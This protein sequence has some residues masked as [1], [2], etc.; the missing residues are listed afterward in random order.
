M[1]RG[2]GQ[3]W[4]EQ[5]SDANGSP[6]AL[7]KVYH[8]AAGT[9]T[10]AN[11][12]SDE[13][14]TTTVAQPLV[15]DSSGRATAY[16]DNLYKIVVK[17]A[18]DNTLYTWDNYR[19]M[20]EGDTARAENHGT[21][22]PA[23]NANNDFMLFA[24]HDGSNI[25]T[26]L[27]INSNN[28][29]IGIAKPIPSS[30]FY[31]SSYASLAAAI[32]A[33]GST[34]GILEF[35][36]TI[37]GANNDTVPS[38]LELK[39]NKGEGQLTVPASSL[40]Y[41][42][43]PVNAGNYQIYSI[44]GSY[45]STQGIRYF[46]S[47]SSGSS[48]SKI[49]PMHF[50]VL[51]DWNGSNEATTATDNS[52]NLQRAFDAV[53]MSGVIEFP[54]SSDRGIMFKDTNANSFAIGGTSG[55]G[56][57]NSNIGCVMNGNIQNVRGNKVVLKY[58]GTA[59]GMY[60]RGTGSSIADIDLVG[61]S[62]ASGGIYL[63]NNITRIDNVWVHGCGGL[64]W[65]LDGA[66][67][68]G[69]VV[70]SGLD[71]N[72]TVNASNLL[73]A[74]T[75]GG[76]PSSTFQIRIN[77]D[78][79][80]E[81]NIL[82]FL[83]C[84]STFS[85]GVRNSAH[86]ANIGWN[87]RGG[88]KITLKNCLTQEGSDGVFINAQDHIV[89]HNGSGYRCILAHKSASATEPGVGASW[90]TYWTAHT[91]PTA[92]SAPA[93]YTNQWA[94]GNFYTAYAPNKISIDNHWFESGTITNHIY[95]DFNNWSSAYGIGLDYMGAATTQLKNFGSGNT[96]WYNGSTN[97]IDAPRLY[98][99]DSQT[100]SPTVITG[101]DSN[102]YTCIT[103]HT[104]AASNRPITGASYTTYWRQSGDGSPA[105]WAT[106]QAYVSRGVGIRS[107]SSNGCGVLGVDEASTGGITFGQF[108][109][110]VVGWSK[111]N[112][113]VG[114][115]G[116]GNGANFAGIFEGGATRIEQFYVQLRTTGANLSVAEAGTIQVINT[117]SGSITMTLPDATTVDNGTW[118]TFLKLVAANSMIIDGYAAQL[119]NGAANI[120]DA[121]AYA[122]YTV[123][124]YEGNWYQIW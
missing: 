59:R 106:G 98:V 110:G 71:Y 37:A 14:L 118:Y 20:A 6:Y 75:W 88:S 116:L 81:S 65:D 94:V 63:Q 2:G 91:V 35:D 105:A 53:P 82:T 11:M 55:G 27:G 101:T 28:A 4:T 99:N 104:S 120:T 124:A 86:G 9:T 57:I 78:A 115:R 43:G 1:S 33:I 15:A 121:T 100:Q 119:V 3:L 48:P 21:A 31:T 19:I 25:F 85:S 47:G 23:D 114:V 108:R 17:D 26:E 18:S 95:D 102:T 89:T 111:S 96:E 5:F 107:S 16:G 113:G 46:K 29:F 34:V 13:G 58:N 12:W 52:A 80:H 70:N 90:A 30:H 66:M 74:S 8:Y 112:N 22:Y 62:S 117:T 50:G 69:L 109:G 84:T 97:G 39:F 122:K 38:T 68:G 73:T 10:D 24:K 103:K 93:A 92:D 45:V 49:N 64:A 76:N 56:Y 44:S 61:N 72:R 32:T 83:Q 79:Q 123:M 51:Y 77:Q 60:F 36:T 54:P 7:C 41:I 67:N 87:I 42:L 40:V